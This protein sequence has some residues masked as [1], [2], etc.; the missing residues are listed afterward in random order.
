MKNLLKISLLA[1]ILLTSVF[2]YASDD[3]GFSLTS[4]EGSE[5][6]VVFNIAATQKIEVI[7]SANDGEVLYQKYIQG[8]KGAKRVY[9]L[10]AFPD[11]NYTFKLVTEKELAEYQISIYNGKTVISEPKFTET[12][13]PSL[14]KEKQIITLNFDNVLKEP[15]EVTIL[16]DRNEEVYSKVFNAK[17]AMNKRFNINNSDAKELTFI[18]KS[19]TQ[20]YIK[21]IALR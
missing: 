12:F 4:T 8:V 19:K 11:G 17:S 6:S 1:T 16:D 13:R 9:N 7:I 14:T 15:V 20:E 10:D 21:V 18:V 5:K 2:T 3:R